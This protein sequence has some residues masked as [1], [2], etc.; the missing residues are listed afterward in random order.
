MT[1]VNF[2][3]ADSLIKRIDQ[4]GA[5]R[6]FESRAG[7]FRYLAIEFLEK[8]DNKSLLLSSMPIPEQIAD[9]NSLNPKEKQIA[10]AKRK[11]QDIVRDQG[12]EYGIPPEAVAQI[13]KV[14]KLMRET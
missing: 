1:R 3:M 9:E 6:G 8:Y 11:L 5:Q 10:E 13:E 7:L 12:I 4:I 14:A 2:D